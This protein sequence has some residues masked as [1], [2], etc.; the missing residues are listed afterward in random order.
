MDSQ[1]DLEDIK[2]TKTEQD[3]EVIADIFAA[4]E[5]GEELL[6]L[7][8]AKI[9]DNK[10]QSLSDKKVA[11]KTKVAEKAEKKGSLPPKM[12]TAKDDKHVVKDKPEEPNL[13]FLW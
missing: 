4:N 6:I 1:D 8:S 7:E 10:K 12:S 11:E 9:S 3:F 13:E 5:I 2:M